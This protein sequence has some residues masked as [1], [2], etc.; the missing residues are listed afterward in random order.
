M[1]TDKLIKL[2]LCLLLITSISI[3]IIQS[4]DAYQIG[5]PTESKY[6]YNSTSKIVTAND[7]LRFKSELNGVITINDDR[8][9]A[10]AIKG[11]I[12]A[13]EYTYTSM[14]FAWTWHVN[15]TADGATFW[16]EN[17]NPNFIWRQYYHFYRNPAKKMKIEHYLE[18]NL[19][20]ISNTQ[21]YYLTNIK[22]TDRL[23]YNGSDYKIIDYFGL[24][25]TGNFNKN[26][27]LL[28]FNNEY[29][30][31]YQDLIDSGF[32]INEFY[33]GSGSV[34]GK[35]NINITAIGFTKNNGNFR[36]GQSV[37]VDPTFTGSWLNINSMAP[38]DNNTFVM[39]L[40]EIITSPHFLSFY[41]YNTNGTALI[42][43][44][45]IVAD[46][47]ESD[48]SVISFDQNTFL[49]TY[50][51]SKNISAK[52]FHRNGSL[53]SSFLIGT[54]ANTYDYHSAAVLDD[55]EFVATYTPV[56]GNMTVA[57]YNKT[58][59]SIRN[60]TLTA[61]NRASVSAFNSS[62]FIVTYVNNSANL[63]YITYNKNGTII[64]NSKYLLY[65][66]TIGE[67][68]RVAAFNDNE[69]V[70]TCDNNDGYSFFAIGNK[71]GTITTPAKNISSIASTDS[72]RLA[73]L[74]SSNFVLSFDS[75][76][77]P[78]KINYSI[79]NKTGNRTSGPFTSH[80]Q[81]S[82]SVI[83]EVASTGI[84]I[85]ND[86]FILANTNASKAGWDA[87]Y[88]NGSVWDGVC[89]LDSTAPSFSGNIS[90]NTTPKI[91]QVVQFNITWEDDTA[92]SSCIFS[93]DN[94]TGTFVNDTA[95]ALSGTKYNCSTNKTIQ[96]VA[97]TNISWRWYAQDSGERWNIST[98]ESFIIQN[99]PLTFTNN[100]TNN[101]RANITQT[102]QFNI[103]FTDQDLISGF[104]FSWDNGTGTFVND[105]FRSSGNVSTG[106]FSVNKTIERI[107]GTT[108]QWRWFANDTAHNWNAS[109]IES[110][111]V[112]NT[113]PRFVQTIPSYSISHSTNIFIDVNCTDADG[114]TVTYLDNTS[115]FNIN[116][117]DGNISDNPAQSEK[118]NYL[119]L[120]I[121]NDG[122]LNTTQT[123][124][125]NITNALPVVASATIND[126]S[127]TDGEDL[128]CI[129]GS[130]SDTDGDTVS[131]SFEWYKNEA[132]QSINYSVL[133][134]GNTSA[135]EQWKCSV[136]PFDGYENGTVVSSS[137]VSI[138]TSYIAPTINW[139]N[140]TTS[141]TGINST[142][143]N[144]TNN[145][146]WIN[147]SVTFSDTNNGELHT[148]FFCK[149]DS[150]TSAGCANGAYCNST[151]NST[152]YPVLSCEYNVSTQTDQTLQYYVYILDNSSLISAS[153]TNNFSVNHFP[154]IPTLASP[155]NATYVLTN[156]VFFNL[157]VTDPDSDTINLS[158]YASDNINNL[159]RIYNGTSSTYN[160]T[161]LNDTIYYVKSISTDQHGYSNNI[162]SSLYQVWIDTHGPI[163]TLNTTSNTTPRLY[164]Q[165][166][167]NISINDSMANVSG[168]IFSWD[169][170]TGTFVNDSFRQITS[171]NLSVSVNKTIERVRA[172][173]VQWKWYAND[174][175]G[176]WNEST[177][178]QLTVRDTL[179]TLPSILNPS[180]TS[181]HSTSSLLINYSSLDNDSDTI[182][183]YVYI[184]GTLN[185]ST[186]GNWSFNASDSTYEFKVM[187]STASGNSSNSSSRTFRLDTISPTLNITSPVSGGSYYSKTVTFAYTYSE[188][189]PA[190]CWFNLTRTGSGDLEGSSKQSLNCTNTSRYITTD[191]YSSYTIKL[192]A[193]DTTG[194][195]ESSQVSF[196][197]LETP[198]TSSTGGGGSTSRTETVII[199]NITTILPFCG[200]NTC[201]DDEAPW[202]CPED[203]RYDFDTL[204]KLDE[205]SAIQQ[206]WFASI[207]IYT[208]LVL[209]FIA[210]AVR[211]VTLRKR[212]RK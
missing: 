95:I 175:N 156:Y 123:F 138:A 149:T 89:D 201:Q 183:Y 166:Q 54:L 150:A 48:I 31:V 164:D 1:N 41:I 29:G 61:A 106:T 180:N 137:A 195:I 212:G 169:N 155:Q 97:G 4:S 104:I 100:L 102:V 132:A 208:L 192:F 46:N 56:N 45:T 42:S 59:I 74:N 112:P 162:N 6:Y 78:S 44:Q 124:Y 184:N 16:A 13:T 109:T 22:D 58:G 128:L 19:A 36:K 198:S 197:T 189:F 73:I 134:N 167:L 90:N 68:N 49:I 179:V 52:V 111:I 108:M 172:T 14:D 87:Y 81:I 202:S 8:Y 121:C 206:A 114:A 148:A 168:F 122:E 117:T 107:N 66:G 69:F 53:I 30:L 85:C 131:I 119:V 159:N 63:N 130:L 24:H 136:K 176:L 75:P 67:D 83:S 77:A 178:E 32:D 7:G 27:P 161:N 60:I 94:G 160:W 146:S 76:A 98:L 186:T 127:P 194:N 40:Q 10:F 173:I 171:G 182:T 199:Q 5:V 125:Y 33:I 93:W 64:S 152:D 39:S 50:Q 70:V 120:L 110:F 188:L 2:S 82:G 91:Y 154:S 145:N 115:L 43:N 118:G 135:G 79:Y 187:A 37:W 142:G 51:I 163:F 88:M 92:L 113:A 18:N 177:T 101:S 17:D 193:N 139:T 200:D 47:N 80:Y 86:N 21:M 210:V 26:L 211:M 15:E 170:G 174:S 12:G 116:S 25:K 209:S 35:P 103:T 3:F 34:I 129:N 143:A 99:T 57:I 23:S 105:S 96:R 157:T 84:Q 151:I 185:G 203:C 205:G 71:N 190:E 38:L 9:L 181:N 28:V 204:F 207:V 126:T 158:I 147:L 72:P 144:P 165:I 65:V 153:R 11:K 55:D 141:I 20:D 196:T 140:A 133:G 191:S 62:S